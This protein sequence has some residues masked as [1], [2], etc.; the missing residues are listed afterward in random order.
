MLNSYA[1]FFL[2]KTRWSS[3]FHA[4][5]CRVVRW[6]VMCTCQQK[7]SHQ[8]SFWAEWLWKT[9]VPGSRCS[10]NNSHQLPL[11]TTNSCIFQ[12]S[13]TEIPNGMYTLSW[14][15]RFCVKAMVL[16]AKYYII[17]HIT[18]RFWTV[19]FIIRIRTFSGFYYTC[20]IPC[21]CSSFFINF[22]T[23]I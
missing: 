6:D 18:F 4:L 9:T 5:I 17:V 3:L 7:S 8:S 14:G 20:V 19:L 13:H 23:D 16:F 15:L 22:Y 2:K 1:N 10:D 21:T 12:N 11:T